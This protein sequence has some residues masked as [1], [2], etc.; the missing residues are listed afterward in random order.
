[1]LWTV[2]VSV[3]EPD[4]EVTLAVVDTTGGRLVESALVAVDV[5]I[6]ALESGGTCLTVV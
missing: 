3:E 6:R 5:A 1:M 4:D 2:T